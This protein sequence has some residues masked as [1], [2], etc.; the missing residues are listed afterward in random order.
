MTKSGPKESTKSKVGSKSR[1]GL[2]NEILLVLG[3]LFVCYWW[4]IFIS[5]LSVGINMSFINKIQTNFNP[6]QNYKFL[7]DTTS[8]VLPRG[9]IKSNKDIKTLV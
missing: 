3:M 2:D 8:L 9:N 5:I 7:K 4:L 6:L 1:K